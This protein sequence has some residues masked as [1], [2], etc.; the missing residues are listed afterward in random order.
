[1]LVLVSKTV[2]DN[3]NMGVYDQIV[4]M[5]G[6]PYMEAHAEPLD[7]QICMATIIIIPLLEIS[8]I[9]I[10]SPMEQSSKEG[11]SSWCSYR[12]MFLLL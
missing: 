12:K 8:H 1:M 11:S 7:V 6:L 4:K 3:F 5:K 2:A 10:E 9:W